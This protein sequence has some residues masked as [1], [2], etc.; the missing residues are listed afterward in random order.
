MVSRRR[1]KRTDAATLKEEKWA[2][3]LNGW[4]KNLYW[5]KWSTLEHRLINTPP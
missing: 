4:K 1:K 5:D 2:Y 3:A